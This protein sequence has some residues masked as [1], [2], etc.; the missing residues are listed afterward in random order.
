MTTFWAAPE[1]LKGEHPTAAAGENN[2]DVLDSVGLFILEEQSRSN[3]SCLHYS[4]V[5]RYMELRMHWD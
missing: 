2:R 5:L 3:I 4:H 1:V